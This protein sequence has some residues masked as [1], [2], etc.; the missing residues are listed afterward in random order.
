MYEIHPCLLV[1]T[2]MQSSHAKQI[3]NCIPQRTFLMA[4]T[5]GGGAKSVVYT[6]QYGFFPLPNTIYGWK[7]PLPPLT[8]CSQ[9]E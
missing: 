5:E 7:Q 6:Y 1:Q 4:A 8:S 9:T 3:H 2:A